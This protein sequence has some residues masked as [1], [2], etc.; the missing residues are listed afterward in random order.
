MTPSALMRGLGNSPPPMQKVRSKSLS[1]KGMRRQSSKESDHGVG[2]NKNG[3]ISAKKPKLRARNSFEESS[4]DENGESPPPPLLNRPVSLPADPFHLKSKLQSRMDN[5]R[6]IPLHMAFKG[7]GAPLSVQF[8]RVRREKERAQRERI[9]H[10]QGPSLSSTSSSSSFSLPRARPPPMSH[11]GLGKR[12]QNASESVGLI[13]LSI[14]APLSPLS[15]RRSVPRSDHAQPKPI[16]PPGALSIFRP[17]G[18]HRIKRLSAKPTQSA[19]PLFVKPVKTN[20]PSSDRSFSHAVLPSE[21]EERVLSIAKDRRK[22]RRRKSPTGS[23]VST[24][25]IENAFSK[26]DKRQRKTPGV[27]GTT[28]NANVREQRPFSA[29]SSVRKEAGKKERGVAPCL[30]KLLKEDVEDTPG[31]EEKEGIFMESSSDMDVDNSDSDISVD[32]LEILDAIGSEKEK[33]MERKRKEMRKKFDEERRKMGKAEILANSSIFIVSPESTGETSESVNLVARSMPAPFGIARRSHS[34]GGI[35]TSISYVSNIE[36]LGLHFNSGITDESTKYLFQAIGEIM[37]KLRIIKLSQTNVGNETCRVI[38]R[39][40]EKYSRKG[41]MLHEIYL[42]ENKK[43]DERGIHTL[44]QI[45]IHQ[46]L[47][48][49]C[50]VKVSKNQK[51]EEEKKKTT[52]TVRRKVMFKIDISGCGH[53]KRDETWDSRII[54]IP[55]FGGMGNRFGYGLNRG[56]GMIQFGRF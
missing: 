33:E 13:P 42:Q 48:E 31:K 6:P 16:P 1:P 45:F 32:E 53:M 15:P 2:G 7:L 29:P 35:S 51:E 23:D 11:M 5:G 49:I 3:S 28:L 12:P 20:Q 21:K 22:K 36:E 40:F 55:M 38:Y 52:R 8:A 4:S 9:L 43:I 17:P 46:F 50:N 24:S 41:A 26:M 34:G 14:I 30:P 25:S 47:P 56:G 37:K 44:N 19:R 39:Y 27:F 54:D 18:H 10:F